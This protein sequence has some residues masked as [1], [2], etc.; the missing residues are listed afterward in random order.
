MRSNFAVT[1]SR[2]RLRLAAAAEAGRKYACCHT[3]ITS[4]LQYAVSKPQTPA[5]KAFIA[6]PQSPSWRTTVYSLS[7]PGSDLRSRS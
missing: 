3:G 5:S 1:T 7:P 6:T 4:T 2:R